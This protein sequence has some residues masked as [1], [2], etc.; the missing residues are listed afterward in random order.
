MLWR[1]DY[2]FLY[3]IRINYIY[4]K[5]VPCAIQECLLQIK[6]VSA[7]T[8]AKCASQPMTQPLSYSTEIQQR[9]LLTAS[10]EIFHGSHVSGPECNSIFDSMP[11][12]CC[13]LFLSVSTWLGSLACFLPL[14]A[15]LKHYCEHLSQQCFSL[16]V[17]GEKTSVKL[18]VLLFALITVLYYFHNITMN[19]ITWFTAKALKKKNHPDAKSKT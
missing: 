1:H 3:T 12:S 18:L 10:K 19:T 14:T 4:S 13:L 7:A 11:L 15:K 5:C 8:L 16:A 9:Q 2:S 6:T 17:K